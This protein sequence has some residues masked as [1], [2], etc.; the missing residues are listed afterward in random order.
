MHTSPIA[1]AHPVYIPSPCAEPWDAMEGDDKTRLCRRCSKNVYNLTAMSYSEQVAVLASPDGL[2]CLRA[3]LR[4]DKTVVLD[5]CPVWLRPA[6]NG[7][8]RCLAVSILIVSTLCNNLVA[9]ASG[10]DARQVRSIRQ[11]IREQIYD[12]WGFNGSAATDPGSAS[13]K[14]STVQSSDI[15]G[16]VSDERKPSLVYESREQDSRWQLTVYSPIYWT[17]GNERNYEEDSRA[18]HWKGW[19]DKIAPAILE[20]WIK[21]KPVDQHDVV[22]ELTLRSESLPTRFEFVPEADTAPPAFARITKAAIGI[23]SGKHLSDVL[24]TEVKDAK[25]FVLK[26]AVKKVPDGSTA[27]SGTR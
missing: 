13:V 26:L 18:P 27:P 15:S 20:Q 21:E 7:L 2:P 16:S 8:K 11:T 6:R 14:Q 19:L 17:G 12:C 24:P 3:Y 25:F 1:P 10:N 4:P 23:S 5:R 22:A 9:L